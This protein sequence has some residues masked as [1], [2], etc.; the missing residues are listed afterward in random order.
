MK[1]LEVDT[2][3][4]RIGAWVNWNKTTD[5]F[6]FGC[7]EEKIKKIAIAWKPSFAALKQAKAHGANFFIA[8]ESIGVKAVNGSMRQDREFM[9]ESESEL[10]DFLKTSSLVVYRCHDFLDAMP[11]WGVM[12]AWQKELELGGRIVAE[13]YPNI[14]TEIQPISVRSLALH[15]IAKTTDLGQKSVMIS[16]NPDKIVH[17][18]ATGT[19]CAHNI[20]NVRSLG[21]EVSIVVDDAYNS[22]RLGSHMRDLDYPMIIVN[23]GVSEEWAVRNLAQHLRTVFPDVEVMYIPQY[24]AHK[25]VHE[26]I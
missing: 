12:H 19:G 11:E 25:F 17:S 18:V 13:E 14:I 10:F 5:I 6:S 16:G 2:Y 9:L 3:F 15:V 20:Q 1:C 24:C 22:V 23:H 26:N 7:A 4:K 8:H 21:A